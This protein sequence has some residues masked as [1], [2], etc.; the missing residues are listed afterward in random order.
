MEQIHYLGEHLW[1]GV[2]GN[3]LVSLSF[4][5][6]LLSAVLYFLAARSP[7]GYKPYQRVARIGFITHAFAVIGI[8]SL[9]FLLLAKGWFE[10]HYV[11]QH[12]SRD[13]AP[14]YV[15]AA[16]WEGQEGSFLIWT[17]WQALLGLLLMRTSGKWEN[18]S[19]FALSAVQAFLASMVLGRVLY[20]P[21]LG[22]DMNIGLFPF[23]MTRLHPDLAGM[24]FTGLADYLERIDGRGL[25]PALQNYWMTIHPPT[26]FLGFALT[27]IPFSF[28]IA[29]IL[30]R[31]L[32]GWFHAARPWAFAGVA[33]L[34]G[35]I[36]MGGAWAYEALNFGG[37]WAWDPVENASLVPWIT[38]TAGAHLLLIPK[39]NRMVVLSALLLLI[40]SF[41][42]VLYSTFLTRSGVLGDASVH[43][44]TDLGLSGQLLLFLFFFM[45]LPV[46]LSLRGKATRLNYLIASA[47]VLAIGLISDF[48]WSSRT[49]WLV[50]GLV[51]MY[52]LWTHLEKRIQHLPEGI[53]SV[54]NRDFWMFVG[55]LIFCLSALHLTLE[56]SK[57]VINK[58]LGSTRFA[59]STDVFNPVQ[60]ALAFFI[61]ALMGISYLLPFQGGKA[62]NWTRQLMSSLITA[63]AITLLLIAFVPDF[64]S[65]W[66]ISLTFAGAFAFSTAVEYIIQFVRKAKQV[67]GTAMAHIGFA[68]IILGSV[69][70]AGHQQIISENNKYVDLSILN[71]DFS[72]NEHIMLYQGDTV[73]MKDYALVYRGDSAAQHEMFYLVDYLERGSAGWEFSFRLEPKII[74][75]PTMGNVA[76]P[77]T[78]HYWNKDIFTHVSY[79]DLKRMEMRL[80]GDRNTR[81]EDPQTFMI[82]LNDT[83]WSSRAFIVFSGI[84]PISFEDNDS[85]GLSVNPV[86]T[87]HNLQ[88]GIDSLKPEFNI[89]GTRLYTRADSSTTGDIVIELVRIIPEEERFETKITVRKGGDEQDFIIMTAIVFPGINI[90]WTGCILMVLGSLLSVYFRIRPKGNGS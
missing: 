24:P 14:K 3:L 30:Q 32:S 31:D 45:W 2:L 15:F 50:F 82:Q 60:G 8:V 47:A 54:Y 89:L 28:A 25:N 87:V 17:F 58:L 11:M 7:E 90:L 51:S 75:S 6:A 65:F 4:S 26:L 80:K 68:L 71:P 49:L 56:T 53:K 22:I 12:T 44:F 67:T 63:L 38:L 61:L 88:G 35:G 18:G 10:Y 1:P 55:S 48:H 46:M 86:F 9:L 73:Y 33:V 57:P 52:L 78:R 27:V 20:I 36:L 13:L 77:S 83:I 23:E 5:A 81:Y 70:S 34:G 64:S 19:M 43:S 69:V 59:S 39:R 41:V 21:S 74:S 42:L 84:T 16:F 62:G 76:E 40:S 29:G 79:V 66:L 72:N 37:F 85:A